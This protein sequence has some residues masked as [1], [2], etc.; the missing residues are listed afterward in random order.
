MISETRRTAAK[1]RSFSALGWTMARMSSSVRGS[2]RTIQSP[3][4]ASGLASSADRG[5][6]R[7]VQARRQHVDQVDVGGELLVLLLRHAAGDEDAE[8]ADVSCTE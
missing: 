8:M 4:I 6:D 7:L 5:H 1:R 2:K 3:P